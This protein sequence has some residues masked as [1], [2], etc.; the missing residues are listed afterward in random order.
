[1]AVGEGGAVMWYVREYD[2]VHGVLVWEMFGVVV[3]KAK[4]GPSPSL[5]S[6]S[7]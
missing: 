5:Y 6:G 2:V 1:M 4:A 7:R 3:A